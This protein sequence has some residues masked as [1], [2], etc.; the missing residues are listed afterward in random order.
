MKQ[1]ITIE[2]GKK[3]RVITE[4][5]H[6]TVGSIVTAE[7]PHPHIPLCWNFK[8][9]LE[10][11]WLKWFDII[12]VDNPLPTWPEMVPHERH[13]LLGELV[14]AMIYSG[15]AVDAVRKLLEQFKALGYVRSVIL[16]ADAVIDEPTKPQA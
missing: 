8:K 5:V 14:D 3:Y 2:A 1:S 4:D 10:T 11:A 7:Y 13:Q 15:H 6:F 12:P 16:P 9:D